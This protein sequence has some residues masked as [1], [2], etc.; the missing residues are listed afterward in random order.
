[1]NVGHF[2]S[3][4][5]FRDLPDQAV[6]IRKTELPEGTLVTSGIDGLA[7]NSSQF[8]QGLVQFPPLSARGMERAANCQRAD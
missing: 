5:H 4:T 7:E 8:H 3:G 1:M 6:S 2:L